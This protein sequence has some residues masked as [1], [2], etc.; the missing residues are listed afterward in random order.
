MSRNYEP[1]VPNAFIWTG[2][3]EPPNLLEG[4][5][6]Y[7]ETLSKLKVKNDAGMIEVGSHVKLDDLAAPDDNTDL[8]ASTSWHGLLPKLSGIA[9]NVLKG[10]GT[11]GAGGAGGSPVEVHH[12]FFAL[13]TPFSI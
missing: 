1:G 10:D 9:S 12:T 2:L 3:T 6:W 11:W 8:N 13:I 7:D 4:D 5:L